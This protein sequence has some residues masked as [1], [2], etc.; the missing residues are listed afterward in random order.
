MRVIG[1]LL[2]IGAVLS[3]TGCSS[4]VTA[5]RE[6]DKRIDDALES[7]CPMKKAG[8]EP[9]EEDRILRAYLVLSAIADEAVINIGAYSGSSSKSDATAMRC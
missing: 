2:L 7:F 9:S 6:V 4:I 1:L 5:N 3:S 8:A